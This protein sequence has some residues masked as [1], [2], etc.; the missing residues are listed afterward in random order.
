MV[1]EIMVLKNHAKETKLMEKLKSL[2]PN[3]VFILRCLQQSNDK[4]KVGITVKTAKTKL[5]GF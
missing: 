2:A 5:A 1:S 4:E 3:Q